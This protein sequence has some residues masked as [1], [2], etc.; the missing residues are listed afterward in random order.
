MSDDE[1]DPPTAAAADPDM[2]TGRSGLIVGAGSILVAICLVALSIATSHAP[3][4]ESTVAIGT[5]PPTASPPAPGT[6]E[7]TTT[8]APPEPTTTIP[9]TTTTTRKPRKPPT[10]PPGPLT[11]APVDFPGYER[12][13]A[14]VVK[15]DNYDPDARP[16]A[17][18][19]LAD[20]VY[21]EKVEGPVSR[22]AAIFQG[23]DADQIGPVRSA[24]STDVE[25]IGDLNRPLF[26]YSG[27]NGGFQALLGISPLVDVGAGAK[28]GAYWRGGDKVIPHNLYTSSSLLWAGTA[29]AP[30]PALWPFRG[31]KD[32]PGPGAQPAVSATYHFGGGMTLI[33][34]TWDATE[35]KWM[36]MQNGSTH[37][38]LDNWPVGVE[39]VIIQY[40]RYQNSTSQ[41]IYGNPIPE[42]SLGGEGRGWVLT[43]G[44]A[45]P[46]KW[47][48]FG[49]NE[50]ASYIGPD[51]QLIKF[52]P[53]H[54]W[55]AL[56]PIE[57]AAT[58]NFTNGT[59][60]N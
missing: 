19:T 24:R 52:A 7:S 55:I 42:A 40:V 32:A 39:N 6:T 28:G 22:F 31:V 45:I 58:V 41:D 36:R 18:L 37:F 8:T 21:E 43:G 48:R 29:G 15:I 35:K 60:A 3:P 27:A 20:V 30:P 26:A 9:G 2:S 56:V 14:L 1:G 59:A 44:A 25:I 51:E 34:W 50:K 17:G 57:F 46:M 13:Q 10:G 47:L 54:T 12:R 16:Q 33:N 53:G 49:L 11:G 5:T 23:S 4:A 38:D